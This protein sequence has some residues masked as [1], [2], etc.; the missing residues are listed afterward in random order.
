MA[1][2]TAPAADRV[3]LRQHAH[4][5]GPSQRAVTNLA[6]SDARRLEAFIG[7]RLEFAPS[8]VRVS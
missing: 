7:D 6:S 3:A 4:V 8:G 2:D 1:T 5:L